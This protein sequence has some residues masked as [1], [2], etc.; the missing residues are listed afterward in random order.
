MTETDPQGAEADEPEARVPDDREDS[1]GAGAPSGNDPG[2][3]A[4]QVPDDRKAAAK[5]EMPDP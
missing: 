1:A 5:S 3:P 2:G 4:A